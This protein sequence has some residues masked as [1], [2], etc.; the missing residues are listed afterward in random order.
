MKKFI[1][2]LMIGLGLTFLSGCT[3]SEVNEKSNN[4]E[5][6]YDYDSVKDELIRF[7]VIANSDSKEDQELKLKVRDEVI[8]H[9]EPLLKILKVLKNQEK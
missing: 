6:V 9:L 7:H 2:I 4:E 3:S 5:V 8:K 1:Y